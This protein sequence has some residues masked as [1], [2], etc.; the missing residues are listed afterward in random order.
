MDLARNLIGRIN[1]GD[2]LTRSAAT[3]PGQLA[4]VD[5]DRRLTYQDFNAYVNRIAHGLAGLGYER[6]AALAVASGNSADFLAVYYACAK[7][8]VVCVPVNLGWRPDEVVYV[9]GHSRARGIV[10]ESQL[11][12]A[13]RDAIAKVS[14][15]ADVIVAPGTGAGYEAEPADRIWTTLETLGDHERAA[16]P[17]REVDDRDALSYLYTS[18]TT[19]FP[20]GVVGSHL[21]IYLESMS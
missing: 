18:G 17:A 16:E 2:S 11:V 6:G 21:A 19:S 9:L 3:R 8:G 20:K 5:G 1:V 13:M 10:V 4:V 15:V 12:G 14:E 7:L